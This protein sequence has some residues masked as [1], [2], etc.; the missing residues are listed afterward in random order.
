MNDPIV[1]AK[2]LSDNLSEVDILDATYFMPADP[3]QSMSEFEAAHIPGARLFEIDAIADQSQS[4]P[5][6]LPSE[7]G[8]TTAMARLGIDGSK[9][10]VVYDRSVNHFSAPRVWFTLKLFGLQ[11]VHVLD[12]GFLAWQAAGYATGQGS[13]PDDNVPARVKW[14]LDQ[15]RVLSASDIGEIAQSASA[16]ILDA[17]SQPRFEGEAPEPRAGLK[18]GHMPG[19]SCVPFTALTKQNGSFADYEL[20]RQLFSEINNPRPAVTCGSG[21]TACIL[22]LGLER[23]NIQARLY[24]A[25]WMEWGTGKVGKI[26]S[27]A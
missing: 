2:W 4:L 19:S 23:L 22:A 9:P 7:E 8:F 20:L 18:S 15:T 17:R 13:K 1:T 16:Q 27:G 3:A 24:D 10:V 14:S 25:S 26:L 6:M 21:L 11:T 12:G 5:H